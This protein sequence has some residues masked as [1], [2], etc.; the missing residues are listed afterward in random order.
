MLNRLL[1]LENF[2]AF[3][4]FTANFRAALISRARD[5]SF[6][7]YLSIYISDCV[8]KKELGSDTPKWTPPHM[9]E[10]LKICQG[11]RFKKKNIFSRFAKRLQD[12]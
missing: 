1:R 12:R 9:V 8:K 4:Q 7:I 10:A 3:V 6:W 11:D 2:Y 5:F